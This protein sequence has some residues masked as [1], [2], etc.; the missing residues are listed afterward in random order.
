MVFYPMIIAYFHLDPATVGVFLGGTI[1]DVAQVVGAGYSV[2]ETSGNVATFT[3]LLRVAMLLPVVGS[4]SLL[5]PSH[6]GSSAGRR[7]PGFL[8]FFA[9]LVLLNSL[10]LIPQ[11]VLG[12]L[13]SVSRWCLVTA[14]A[15]LGM[16]TSLKAIAEGGRQVNC[17]DHRRDGIPCTA[18]TGH[19]DRLL[20]VKEL[21]QNCVSDRKM[22]NLACLKRKVRL[23]LLPAR[24]ATV[25]SN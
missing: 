22:S 13:K 9:G 6:S 19:R 24:S 10:G 20:R 11:V 16:K 8:L 1:H 23:P 3:K 17:V 2:S 7:L 15:A 14:I 21:G 5:F 25:R 4:L 12:V 18:G